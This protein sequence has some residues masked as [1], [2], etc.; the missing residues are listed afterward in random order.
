MLHNFEQRIFTLTKHNR[1]IRLPRFNRTGNFYGLS[2]HR[3]GHKRNRQTHSVSDFLEYTSLEIGSNRGID[4]LHR[5]AGSH[6]WRCH[7]QNPERRRRFGAR[8]GWEKENYF[9]RHQNGPRLTN[10]PYVRAKTRLSRGCQTAVIS[11]ARAIS[12]LDFGLQWTAL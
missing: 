4:N 3:T 12:G 9:F 5:V 6:E 10:S 8:K 7:R 2:D 11:S 1:K